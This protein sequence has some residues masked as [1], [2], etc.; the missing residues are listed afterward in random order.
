MNGGMDVVRPDGWNLQGN[1]GGV[2]DGVVRA[3]TLD[4]VGLL[5]RSG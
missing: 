1:V 3:Q 4:E 5:T 2:V